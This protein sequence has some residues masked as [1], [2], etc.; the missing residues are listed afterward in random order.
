M[1]CGGSLNWSSASQLVAGLVLLGRIAPDS[2]NPLSLESPYD[3]LV[4]LRTLGKDDPSI[5]SSVGFQPYN[6]S[7]MAAEAIGDKEDPLTYIRMAEKISVRVG[8]GVE[9]EKYARRLIRG[10]EIPIDAAQ[11][12]LVRLEEER[13][14]FESGDMI[15][16]ETD[17]WIPTHWA[18]WDEYFGGVPKYGLVLVGAPPGTGKTSALIKLLDC[19]TK[20]KKKFLFLSLELT[21]ELVL[22][23][24]IEVHPSLNTKQRARL[25]ISDEV[26]TVEEA[27]TAITRQ[28]MKDP[29]IYAVGI[30]F[31]DLMVPEDVGEEVGEASKIYRMLATCAKRLRKPIFLLAQLNS[32]YTGGIPHVN[33]FRYSR[34]AE[35]MGVMIVMIYNPDGIYIDMGRDTKG[36]PLT[37]REGKAYLILGKSR[38]GFLNG[39]PGAVA[40]DFMGRAGWG[41]EGDGW[42][43]L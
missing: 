4:K 15:E 38:F 19:I 22:M 34:L 32:S 41:D 10:E 27:V 37:Y 31:A 5:I 14:Q 12:Q 39:G 21:S 33:H 28:I 24:W 6:T 11:A 16:P 30:D 1:N 36:N 42:T 26:Y 43:K 18:A 13:M 25:I 3:Q 35:A 17:I 2:V 9:L 7:V 20:A 23:R 40:V 8:S 29:D